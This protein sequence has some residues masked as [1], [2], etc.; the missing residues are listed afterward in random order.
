MWVEGEAGEIKE[1]N[2]ETSNCTAKFKIRVKLKY[3]GCQGACRCTS[4][5]AKNIKLLRFSKTY[6][7]VDYLRSRKQAKKN[8][9]V[10]KVDFPCLESYS[11]SRRWRVRRNAS[12]AFDS[13]AT[14][15]RPLDLH[16]RL[17][18]VRICIMDMTASGGDPYQLRSKTVPTHSFDRPLDHDFV[19]SVR[20]ELLIHLLRISFQKKRYV[21][22][23][24]SLHWKYV[25]GV[26]LK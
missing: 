15:R 23:R 10:F 9:R 7:F 12:D 1:K 20:V 18:S 21:A 11:C 22:R 25:K 13:S 3:K 8:R 26:V 2:N 19:F 16:A 14:L 17:P 6:K 4:E 24:D 5:G